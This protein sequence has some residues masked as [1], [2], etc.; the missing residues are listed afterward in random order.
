MPLPKTA[1]MINLGE[2]IKRISRYKGIKQT[3]LARKMGISQQSVSLLIRKAELDDYTL[4]RVAKAIGVTIEEIRLFTPKRVIDNI[5]SLAIN[6]WTEKPDS[7]ILHSML[8]NNNDHYG[9]KIMK[10]RGM[11]NWTQ[12]QLAHKTNMTEKEIMKLEQMPLIG[13]DILVNICAVFGLD[14]NGFKAFNDQSLNVVNFNFFAGSK[15]EHITSI[16]SHITNNYFGYNKP[17]SDSSSVS[18]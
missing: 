12:Q 8:A 5:N 15:N 2:N 1:T 10:L 7:V 18:S 17:E 3:H 14:L 11:F 9:Q 4:Y 13:D 16:N 6:I